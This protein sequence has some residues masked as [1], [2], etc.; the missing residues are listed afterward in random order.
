MEAGTW[1]V[2]HHFELPSF[3]KKDTLPAS[4][5]VAKTR[6][7]IFAMDI[8]KNS[9]LHGHD[10]ID[11]F[12]THALHVMPQ[13]LISYKGNLSGN[14]GSV[15]L[16]RKLRWKRLKLD[17]TDVVDEDDISLVFLLFETHNQIYR[18]ELLKKVQKSDY[19]LDMMSR[20][21]E[22]RRVSKLTWAYRGTER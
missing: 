12:V 18:W 1:T 21:A 3:W 5:R 19:R 10:V 6:L 14:D 16:F 7:R 22:S 17:E 8:Q 4:K 13:M 15:A 2:L 9:K 11:A 20:L